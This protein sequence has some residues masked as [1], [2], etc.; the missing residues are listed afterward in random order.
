MIKYYTGKPMTISFRTITKD[1]VI[2]L[3]QWH[4]APP[5]DVYNLGEEPTD[6][7]LVYYLDPRYRYCV[8]LDA[9]DTVIAFCSFG[10]DGQ[11]PGG[12]YSA[13][14]L[15]IGLGVCPDLTGQGCGSAYVQ[16]V[17]D[18][19]L[20]TFAPNALRVTI[21][22]FNQRAQRL[23]QQAGFVEVSRFGSAKNALPF[24]IYS[25][26]VDDEC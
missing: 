18:F 2:K 10:E 20:A 25:R 21:A 3:F 24:I 8:M 17:I 6:A 1:D 19:A 13:D 4:Y 5:Y 16:Q 12:D 22:A 9:A 7:D 11:V 15:D 26:R 14:A 23:W